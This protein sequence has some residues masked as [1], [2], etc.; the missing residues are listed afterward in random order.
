MTS[1]TN[2]YT[3]KLIEKGLDPETA[4]AIAKKQSEVNRANL[5]KNPVTPIADIKNKDT[6]N[7]TKEEN[8][9]VEQTLSVDANAVI[10]ENPE[11]K[12][13][14]TRADKALITAS[15][16][17]METPPSGNDKVYNHSIFCQVGLPRKKT[18]G[19]SFLRRSG[20]AWV[21]IQSGFLDE[22]EGPVQQPIPYGPIPRLRSRASCRERV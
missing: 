2:D 21:H 15:S 19:S 14:I 13:P 22:G 8:T 11:E 5:K 12:K 4:K 7:N 20:D 3:N 16:E 9:I 1:N 6:T 18:E 10:E 17:I